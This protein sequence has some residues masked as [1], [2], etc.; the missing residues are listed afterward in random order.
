MSITNILLFLGLIFLPLFHW[1]VQ[2]VWSYLRFIELFFLLSIPFLIK[3]KIVINF[4]KNNIILSLLIFLIISVLSSLMGSDLLKSFSGN[5]YRNDGLITFFHL[6]AFSILVGTIYTKNK[7]IF[8]AL[9]IFLG[10]SL[11][12]IFNFFG[13]DNFLAGF[14]LISLPFGIY[15][16]KNTKNKYLKVLISVAFLIQFYRMF[17]IN[18]Y[19]GTLGLIILFPLWVLI[20]SK[21][22]KKIWISIIFIA[23]LITSFFWFKELKSKKE[24]VAES[25]IRIYRNVFLGSL[26]KPYFGYGWTNTDY[27]F[28][29]VSWPLKFNND[30]YVDKAHMLFLEILA[31]TGILGLITYITFLILV[32]K[33]LIKKNDEWSKVLLT[34]FV[35]YLIY[36][37]TNVTSISYE[38]IF[39]LIIG[40]VLSF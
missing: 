23:I 27:A 20:N 1:E 28:E 35:M 17:L 9:G 30:I 22:F 7:N 21:K 37:Q 11:S 29:S 14:I 33:K 19:V 34:S 4:K 38:F 31:T 32:F 8:I 2:K 16:F 6:I 15:L 39:W 36:S 10:S 3:E 40:I 12:S 13:Q 18:S 25:R 5:F 26:K 24:Y